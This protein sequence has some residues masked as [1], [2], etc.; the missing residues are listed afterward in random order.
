MLSIS[1]VNKN[2]KFCDI[3]AGVAHLSLMLA[4]KGFE[5]TAVE[6]N[7]ATRANGIKRTESIDNI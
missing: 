6:P 1:N 3:G 7:D 5:I 4:K 2:N